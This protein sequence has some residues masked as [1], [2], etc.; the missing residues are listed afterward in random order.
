M[1][2]AHDSV[3]AGTYERV[4]VVTQVPT[5][6]S[7]GRSRQ[8]LSPASVDF[9]QPIRRLADGQSTTLGR[10][11]RDGLFPKASNP[12]CRFSLL[13]ARLLRSGGAGTGGHPS[14]ARTISSG[15]PG[16]SQADRQATQALR[17]VRRS[18][19]ALRRRKR[20]HD[21][22]LSSV[23]GMLELAQTLRRTLRRHRRLHDGRLVYRFRYV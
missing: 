23:P 13:L 6:S 8:L 1:P 22:C 3:E 10:E 5:W 2:K 19:K 4:W 9:T 21:R 17:C 20:L 14:R 15:V 7:R 18:S 11:D 12:A 16:S